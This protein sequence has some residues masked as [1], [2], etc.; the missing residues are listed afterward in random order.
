MYIRNVCVFIYL[1]PRGSL[2]PFIS[3]TK[4]GQIEIAEKYYN[5]VN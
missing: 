5:A 3:A 2:F 4:L 1:V